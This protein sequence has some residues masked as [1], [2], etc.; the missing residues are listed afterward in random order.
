MGLND[1]YSQA[2]SQILMK[3]KMLDVNQA[4]ALIVQDES[5]RLAVGSNF[6]GYDGAG[7][8]STVLFTARNAG[9]KKK[10]WG[11]MCDFCHVK[12]HMRE[13]CFKLMKCA[14]CGK[15]DM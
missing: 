11:T 1:G 6:S 8:N 4:Y 12:G 2:R 14:H 15:Q 5:Q 7:P 10:S 3:S 9:S 13:D